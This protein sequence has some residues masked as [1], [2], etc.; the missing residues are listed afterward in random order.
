MKTGGF[1]L[2]YK[3]VSELMKISLSLAQIFSVVCADPLQEL[4]LFFLV[5]TVQRVHSVH[6]LFKSLFRAVSLRVFAQKSS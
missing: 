2:A 1:V 4:S 3:P 6:A 5:K